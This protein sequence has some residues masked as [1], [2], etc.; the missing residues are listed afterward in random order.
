MERTII[1]PPII[2]RQRTPSPILTKLLSSYPPH[3]PSEL[4]N[5]L[6]KE[7]TII[8]LPMLPSPP[9]QSPTSSPYDSL[10]TSDFPLEKKQSFIIAL[11]RDFAVYGAPA[12]RY[13]LNIIIL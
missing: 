7:D 9:P 8:E 3:K 13:S 5:E 11:A 4:Q 1:S 6:E 2:A 12:H 10:A